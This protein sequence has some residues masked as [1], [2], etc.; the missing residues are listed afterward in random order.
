MA[1]GRVARA[2]LPGGG[3]RRRGH[4]RRADP[5]P[6]LRAAR[7]PARPRRLLL[8]ARRRGR[9]AGD[10]A[11]PAR[12]RLGRRARR[13]EHARELAV[14]QR[15]GHAAADDPRRR[16]GRPHATSR[17]SARATSTRPSATSSATPGSTRASTPSTARSHAVDCVYVA[18]DSDGLDEDEVSSFMPV[19][20]GIRLAEAVETLPRGSPLRR[21]F[22]GAGFTGL[23]PDERNLEPATRLA[24]GARPVTGCREPGLRSEPWPNPYR[25][26]DRAQG[27]HAGPDDARKHPNTCPSCGSHYRDDELEQAPRRLPAVRP[28]LPALGARAHRHL[29][30]PGIVLRGGD[31]SCARP[32]RSTSSTCARTPSGSPRPS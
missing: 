32:T 4:A 14:R 6:R 8:L 13:P 28:P 25:R 22:V 29:A 2:P 1:R 18:L 12:G 19:P 31:A 21:P 17:S 16:R 11:R 15:V 26:L 30:D 3:G 24:L 9:G 10:P 23:V 27:S 5:R 20:G 7:A